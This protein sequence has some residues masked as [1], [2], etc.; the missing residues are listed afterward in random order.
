VY[1]GH[2][3]YETH[4]LVYGF[5][6]GEMEDPESYAEARREWLSH[7]RDVVWE[8]AAARDERYGGNRRRESAPGQTSQRGSAPAEGAPAGGA[9]WILGG[10]LIVS[11]DHADVKLSPGGLMVYGDDKQ[12]EIPLVTREDGRDFRLNAFHE[13]ITTGRPLQAD[14]AWGRA[15]VEVLLA[16][17]QSGRERREVVLERQTA[18]PSEY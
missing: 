1:S 17:E 14:G 16:I 2:D 6:P 18:Y 9:G 7:D 4:E 5:E 10:P 3:H 11:Y 8:T 13:A 12:W 15:T